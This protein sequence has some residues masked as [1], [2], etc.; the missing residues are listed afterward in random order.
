MRSAYCPTSILAAAL[1]FA[2][3]GAC[4]SAKPTNDPAQATDTSSSPSPSPTATEALPPLTPFS[5][6]LA[7]KL[8]SIRDKV[9]E[10]RGLPVYELAQEGVARPEDLTENTLNQ[11]AELEPDDR[12][13]GDAAVLAMQMLQLLP[14]DYSLE[15]LA[16]DYS[17]N[18][19]GFYSFNHKALVLVGEP[20]EE[21]SLLDESV[22]AHEYTHSLQDGAFNLEELLEKYAEYS[23]DEEG[24]TSYAETISCIIEGDAV[25]TQL[26]YLEEIYGEDWRDLVQDESSSD[27]G[28]ESALPEFLERAIGFDYSECYTFVSQLY[29]DGGWDAVN[30][31]FENP[32]ATTEQ[33]LDIE[34]F[35][36]GEIAN[37]MMPDDLTADALTGWTAIDLGQ[38]GMFDVYNYVL[39]LTGDYLS[40]TSA[41]EGWGSGWLRLYKS[42]TDESQ[43]MS[44]YLSFDSDADLS[45]FIS[46][47]G[48]ILRVYDV[49]DTVESGRFRRFTIAGNPEYFGAIGDPGDANAAE[50]LLSTDA[51][52]L[53]AALS[54]LP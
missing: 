16:S 10:I 27:S 7:D 34:K 41:S 32:P 2:V 29:E 48:D 40:A 36:D 20:D 4:N 47:F 25:F 31:A 54:G 13:E 38:F 50:L 33:I 6:Q 22:L 49:D 15:E 12:A 5:A 21:I 28:S 39:T 46:A 43:I 44:V 3:L 35:H 18:I 17:G 45:E 9:S 42:D 30:D 23:Q 1:L 8:H 14:P 51:A 26:M 11:F 24:Y 52:S 19:A 37:G 53:T